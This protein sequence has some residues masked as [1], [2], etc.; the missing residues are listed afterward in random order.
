[1]A[2]GELTARVHGRKMENDEALFYAAEVLLGLEGIH[3]LGYI[4][5]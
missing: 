3:A 2:G 4:Y 5:R 1:M